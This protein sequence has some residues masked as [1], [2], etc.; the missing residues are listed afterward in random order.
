MRVHLEE[1]KFLREIIFM[2]V[3]SIPC[4]K[5]PIGLMIFGMISL[6]IGLLKITVT[7]KK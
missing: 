1:G 2:A 7:S 6:T 3:F 5:V 4:W